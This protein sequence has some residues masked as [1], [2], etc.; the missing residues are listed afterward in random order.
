[1]PKPTRGAP[2]GTVAQAAPRSQ[3]EPNTGCHDS[4]KTLER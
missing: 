2:T 3:N 4:G 1:M